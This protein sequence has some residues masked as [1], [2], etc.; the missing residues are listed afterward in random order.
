MVT[1]NTEDFSPSSGNLTFQDGQVKINIRNVNVFNL[2]F[3]YCSYFEVIFQITVCF[4]RFFAGNV[5]K[6][7]EHRVEH[8]TRKNNVNSFF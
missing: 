5:C 8:R 1:A 3:Y 7:L 6:K 2:T 4:T